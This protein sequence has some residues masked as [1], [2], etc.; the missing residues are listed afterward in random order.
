MSKFLIVVPLS[1][2]Q[3]HLADL[4]VRSA[5][6]F[7]EA[8]GEVERVGLGDNWERPAG[9]KDALPETLKL[10]ELRTACS[11]DEVARSRACRSLEAILRSTLTSAGARAVD[12]RVFVCEG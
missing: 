6:V 5:A 12:V 3:A 10:V 8:Q 7:L 4:V 1:K 2:D 11:L 9:R